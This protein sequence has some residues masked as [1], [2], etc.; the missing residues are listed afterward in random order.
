MDCR[1]I[2]DTE[3]TTN[4]QTAGPLQRIKHE[5]DAAFEH[6]EAASLALTEITSKRRMVPLEQAALAARIGVLMSDLQVAQH[7]LSTVS[8][9]VPSASA[10]DGPTHRSFGGPDLSSSFLLLLNRLRG[11]P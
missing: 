5:L 8:V 1:E 9:T 11:N 2:H 7:W 6:M 3:S 4:G 10:T